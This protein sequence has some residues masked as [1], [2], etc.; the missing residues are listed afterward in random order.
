MSKPRAVLFCPG[1]GSYG[2]GELGFLSAQLQAGE[3]RDALVEVEGR[4]QAAGLPS[5][6]ELDT[7]KSF[8]PSQHLEGRN[9]SDLLY[10]STMAHAQ[11]LREKYEIIAVAGNSLGW[12]TALA[13]AGSLSV[14]DGWQLVSTMARM[15]ELAAGGQLLTTILDEDWQED[16]ELVEGMRRAMADCL[17]KGEE[18]FVALSIRLGGHRVIAGREKGIRE[19]LETLPQV[20]RGDRKFPFQLAGHGPFHTPLCK[21]VSAMAMRELRALD[22]V[23]PRLHLIDGFGDQHSPWS[24]DPAALYSYTAG[25]QVTETF[26]FSAAVRTALREFN[27]EVLLCAGPGTS[28]RAPVGHVVLAEGYRA[29]HSKDGLAK[30]DLVRCD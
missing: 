16:R 27:P 12:Y 14:L 19:L 24:A 22:F 11:Q 23:A 15:Q 29:L 10:F 21:E 25:R 3:L 18:Y 8:R 1:R 9:A 30:S 2:K 4:R 13:A 28:L 7:A 20:E 6:L 5:L 17:S 26:D